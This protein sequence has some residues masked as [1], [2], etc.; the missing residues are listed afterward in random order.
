MSRSEESGPP[1]PIKVAGQ[2]RNRRTLPPQPPRISSVFTQQGFAL[3]LDFH[4]N[5]PDSSKMIPGGPPPPLFDA[6][7]SRASSLRRAP[8]E[9]GAKLPGERLQC[10]IQHGERPAGASAT[11]LRRALDIARRPTRA[12]HAEDHQRDEP[13]GSEPGRTL[14][15]IARRASLVFPYP[16]PRRAKRVG[17]PK[18]DPVS[19]PWVN[20]QTNFDPVSCSALGPSLGSRFHELVAMR[21][22]SRIENAF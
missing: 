3:E 7:T 1:E 5:R 17:R 20:A 16:C 11:P 14:I 10:F 19:N 4:G 15:S 13:G 9:D 8:N 2:S 22:T 6:S 12:T 21:A 18:N